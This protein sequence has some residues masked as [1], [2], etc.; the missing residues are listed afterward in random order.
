MAGRPSKQDNANKTEVISWDK[1]RVLLDKKA[2]E[3]KGNERTPTN[4]Y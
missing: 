4:T 1:D 2:T 3:E